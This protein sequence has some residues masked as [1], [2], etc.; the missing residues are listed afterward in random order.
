MDSRNINSDENA[1]LILEAEVKQDE[2]SVENKNNND[3]IEDDKNIEN[4][5]A[6]EEETFN[7]QIKIKEKK[8]YKIEE[9]NAEEYKNVLITNM[10][11]NLAYIFNGVTGWGPLSPS[12]LPF[13]LFFCFFARKFSV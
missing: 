13:F 4:K 11:D 8:E 10:K 2:E 6:D 7:N 3:N 5:K 12:L 9:G 1:K